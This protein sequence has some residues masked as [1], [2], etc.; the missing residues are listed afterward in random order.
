[1]SY[2]VNCGVELDRSLKKCPLCGVPVINPLEKEEPV[3]TPAFPESRDELKKKD[4]SFWIGFFS[5]LY[6]VPIV[7]CVICNLLYDKSLT[8]SVYVASGILMLWV[9]STSPFYFTKFDVRAMISIDL[10]GVLLG[11]TIIQ[12]MTAAANWF[13]AIA[14]PAVLYCW[15]ALHTLITLEIKKKLRGLG[16][17]AAYTVATAVLAVLVD[18]LVDLYATGALDLSW[19][20][21]VIAPCL[22]IAALLVLLDKN[23]RFRQEFAKRLHV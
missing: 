9:F 23:K 2:C 12:M 16:I 6:T 1:M 20:W 19:S 17:A 5:L 18:L 7:T 8:W 4:R 10:A 15:I 21:F 13:V 11:M 14:L 3:Q 22:A